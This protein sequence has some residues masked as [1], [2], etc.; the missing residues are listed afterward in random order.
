MFLQPD[1]EKPHT[2]KPS[3]TQW[4]GVLTSCSTGV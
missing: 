1:T 3:C 4:R 2:W